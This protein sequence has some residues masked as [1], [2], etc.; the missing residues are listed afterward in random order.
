MFTCGGVPYAGVTTITL[1]SELSSGHRL[2]KPNNAACSKDMYV[3]A[4][5]GLDSAVDGYQLMKS[6]ILA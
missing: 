2:D 6:Q 3:C 4:C 5:N 1:L